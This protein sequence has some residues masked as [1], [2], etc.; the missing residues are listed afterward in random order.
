MRQ[1]NDPGRAVASRSAGM[2][3]GRATCVLTFWK[4]PRI[5]VLP[6][7]ALAGHSAQDSR[8]NYPPGISPITP[9]SNVIITCIIT[10][11]AH[12]TSSF[13]GMI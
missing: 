4:G 2:L 11:G 10:W 13:F 5:G 7:S 9:Q 12:A 8:T 1:T 3:P 6:N